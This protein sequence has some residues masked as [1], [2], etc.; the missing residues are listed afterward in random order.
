MKVAPKFLVFVSFATVAV[1]AKADPFAYE[2]PDGHRLGLT[3]LATG[4][5]T[6]I[7]GE[8]TTYL[9]GIGVAADNKLYG[10][11]QFGNEFVQIDKATGAQTMISTLALNG[12]DYTFM[13]GSTADGS[14]YI[15]GSGS[16]GV[17]LYRVTPTGSLTSLGLMTSGGVAV[18]GGFWGFST[19]SST[20]YMTIDQ[21]LYTVETTTAVATQVGSGMGSIM[22]NGSG[23]LV[24]MGGVL[25]SAAIGFDPDQ[26]QSIVTVDKTTSA[27][28]LL[29]TQS[30]M[31]GHWAYGFAP[32]AVPEPTSL[33]AVGLGL[34]GL[35]VRRRRK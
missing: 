16:L 12:D 32:A 8:F 15:G 27:A 7:G 30:G 28:T 10:I 5:F 19:G 22:G 26:L 13:M 21:N 4:D 25:Y 29:S 35:A 6:P 1:A 14:M 24:E 34:A 33:A 31:N 2:I 18:N 17:S 20:L 23:A 3:N 9:N 11:G